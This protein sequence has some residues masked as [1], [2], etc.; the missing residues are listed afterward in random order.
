MDN[1]QSVVNPGKQ[2]MKIVL[3]KDVNLKQETDSD[4]T[5]YPKD[6]SPRQEAED[7]EPE[8]SKE[9]KT[10]IEMTEGSPFVSITTKEEEI[11]QLSEIDLGFIYTICKR[12]SGAHGER[13]DLI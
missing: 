1:L 8:N 13:K 6:A 7:S 12:L 5:V 3:P 9:I 11:D 10:E 2:E 4:S